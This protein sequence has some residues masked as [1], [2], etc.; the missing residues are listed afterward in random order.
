M[1]QSSAFSAALKRV[2]GVATTTAEDALGTGSIAAPMRQRAGKHALSSVAS[3]FR[4][5]QVSCLMHAT[6]CPA[7]L[8]DE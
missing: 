2:F 8:E 6:H 3:R 4:L 7:S 1:T 5:M